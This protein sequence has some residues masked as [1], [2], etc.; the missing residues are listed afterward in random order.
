MKENNMS[1]TFTLLTTAAL[2]C[3]L[4]ASSGVARAQPG[5]SGEEAASVTVRYADL[6]VDRPAGAEILLRRITLAAGRVCGGQPDA[7]A[8]GH[9]RAFTA[10]RDATVAR[11]VARVGAPALLARHQERFVLAQR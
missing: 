10:C 11:A 8:W 3:G 4:I 5:L 6:D 9:N 7:R 1:K 2:A